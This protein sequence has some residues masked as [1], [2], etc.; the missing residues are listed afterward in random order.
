LKQGY[1]NIYDLAEH[2]GVTDEF[3]Q[4]AVEYYKINN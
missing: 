2:F 4:K 1:T 3:M